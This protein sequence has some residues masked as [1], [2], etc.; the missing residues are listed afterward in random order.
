MTAGSY[1]ENVVDN[2]P[3]ALIVLLPVMALAYCR[4]CT[5]C[6]VATMSNTCCFSFTFHAFFFLIL[7][8]ADPGGAD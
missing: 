5:R 3:A 6:H 7:I 1:L 2:I 8:A 4:S